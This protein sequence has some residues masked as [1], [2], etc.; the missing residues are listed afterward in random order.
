MT[1]PKHSRASASKKPTQAYE[2]LTLHQKTTSIAS[3]LAAKE[4]DDKTSISLI[5]TAAV[6]W[7]ILKDYYKENHLPKPIALSSDRHARFKNRRG[8][9]KYT[10]HGENG[11]VD[12]IVRAARVSIL[13]CSNVTGSDKRKLFV[14]SKHCPK[15]LTEETLSR[16]DAAT[17]CSGYMIQVVSRIREQEQSPTATAPYEVPWSCLVNA[18]EKVTPDCI[19]S[20]FVHVP[21]LPAV[22]RR[23]LKKLGIE[24]KAD[25]I[26][27]LQD[28]LAKKYHSIS[29]VIHKQNDFSV[30]NYL[31]MC[32][33][34]GPS[35]SV[36]AS[37]MEIINDE[38][39]QGVFRSHQD[40][41][42]IDEEKVEDEEDLDNNYEQPLTSNRRLTVHPY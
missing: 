42:F 30:L 12:L 22:H 21:T 39:Y 23:A 41:D 35:E 2:S 8:L 3:V 36:L 34:E 1:K 18:W 6:Q 33:S 10:G 27:A 16:M 17:R 19:R 13:L 38:K 7:S 37:A 20:C 26:N 11:S 14:L 29:D 28:K 5:G 40:D 15:D 9:K 25:Q 32:N 4:N 31:S 24:T